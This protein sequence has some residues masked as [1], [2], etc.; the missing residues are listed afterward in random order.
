MHS[1]MIGTAGNDLAQILSVAFRSDRPQ[2]ISQVF[3]TV[4]CGRFQVIESRVDFG[5][6]RFRFHHGIAFGF[7]QKYG[8]A[9]IDGRRAAA[10]SII[11]GLYRSFDNSYTV[12]RNRRTIHWCILT[13]GG[14]CEEQAERRN[15]S[16]FVDHLRK[17][18]PSV[19]KDAT[20]VPELCVS[21]YCYMR[22]FSD[23]LQSHANYDI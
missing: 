18:L 21:Q 19:S 15:P 9:K 17:P 3:V 5:T 7:R 12:N 16:H 11:D 4:A 23:L 22:I 2:D 20:L 14:G 8:A 1:G 10:I 6:S 13:P